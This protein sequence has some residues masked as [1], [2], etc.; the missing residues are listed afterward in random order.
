MAVKGD[1]ISDLPAV[2]SAVTELPG[3][4]FEVEV[5]TG[6]GAGAYVNKRL[7]AEQLIDYLSG[8][9]G[10]NVQQVDLLKFT[11]DQMNQVM[12]LTYND[13]DADPAASP[14][15]S[16]PGMQ[17]DAMCADGKKRNFYCTRG[18]YDPANPN[19]GV[20][21]AWHRQLKLDM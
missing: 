20:G 14:S 9:V 17:F 13:C 6:P 1:T 18:T 2:A 8:K 12:G 7:T 19:S 21:P 5:L 16:H 10:L 4:L 3:G 15:W 11:I